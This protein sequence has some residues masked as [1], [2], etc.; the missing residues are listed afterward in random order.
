MIRL[1]LIAISGLFLV[2][3]GCASAEK[4]A[5]TAPVTEASP[6]AVVAPTVDAAHVE[7]ANHE[8]VHGAKC[9]HKAVKHGTHSDYLHDGHYHAAHAG[10]VDEHGMAKGSKDACIHAANHDHKHNKS[11]GHDQV[12]HDS[13]VDYMHDGHMHVAHG[14]HVDEHGVN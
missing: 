13:H 5:E 4:K 12:K 10:H 11:C 2:L 6:A 8:H 14:E 1:S 3:A 9:G 7:H